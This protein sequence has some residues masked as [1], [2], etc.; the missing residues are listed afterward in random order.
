MYKSASYKAGELPKT[1]KLID[2]YFVIIKKGEI[3]SLL[4]LDI[5]NNDKLT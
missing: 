4:L 2:V 1:G 5:F 3:I